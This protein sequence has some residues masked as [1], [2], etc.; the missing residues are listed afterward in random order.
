MCF[1]GINY[2]FESESLGIEKCFGGILDAHYKFFPINSQ[3]LQKAQ[4]IENPEFYA[5]FFQFLFLFIFGFL[6][7]ILLLKKLENL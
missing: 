3:E 2:Y 7:T 5:Y 4:S 6:A 1:L